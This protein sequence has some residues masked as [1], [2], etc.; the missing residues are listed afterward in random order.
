MSKINKNPFENPENLT[1]M[2]E[3]SQR[4][5]DQKAKSL[6]A[7]VQTQSMSK[8]SNTNP[9]FLTNIFTMTQSLTHISRLGFASLALFTI[10]GG[11]LTAQAFAPENLKPVT[12]AN[13]LF[14]ANKQSD[15]N[16]KSVVAGDKQNRV[17]LVGECDLAIKYPKKLNTT[18]VS[19]QYSSWDGKT[20]FYSKYYQ[21]IYTNGDSKS[22]DEMSVE[23]IKAN[24]AKFSEMNNNF[25]LN[26]G[27]IDKKS[28]IQE[29]RDGTNDNMSSK[30]ETKALTISELQKMTG[31]FV[32]EFDIQNISLRE[33]VETTT[34]KGVVFTEKFQIISFDYE[35]N[36]Y[37]IK[38]PKSSD[39]I[40]PQ[41]IQLQFNSK[42]TNKISQYFGTDNKYTLCDHVVTLLDPDNLFKGNY[43]MNTG[44]RPYENYTIT[45]IG[46]SI[47]QDP[48]AVNVFSNTYFGVGCAKNELKNDLE[49]GFESDFPQTKGSYDSLYGFTEDSKQFIDQDSIYFRTGKE[50]VSKGYQIRLKTGQ[51]IDFGTDFMDRNL[52]KAQIKLELQEENN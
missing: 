20:T 34:L 11:G 45:S 39:K 22:L 24:N 21:E 49:S 48:L 2:F 3:S 36:T 42:V 13:N 28:L 46:F 31:W 10:I 12:L 16:P 51:W 38:F 37:T 41:D 18:P 33:V 7:F 1:P 17:A 30:S 5:Q 29:Y 52:L 15:T 27:K 32:T 14:S 35:N 44:R 25:V 6:K 26:C 47:P 50:G 4:Y 9:S 43:S 19:T 23:E 40:S 8:T